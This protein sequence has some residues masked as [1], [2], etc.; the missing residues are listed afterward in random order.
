M[1]TLPS[2]FASPP[3]V[4]MTSES[5]PVTVSIGVRLAATR[6]HAGRISAGPVLPGR[7]G[8]GAGVGGAL[9]LLSAAGADAGGEAGGRFVLRGDDSVPGPFPAVASGLH[10][11]ADAV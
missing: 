8:G 1:S 6:V 4:Y 9:H 10:Q 7:G 11:A 3:Y 2:R 5:L